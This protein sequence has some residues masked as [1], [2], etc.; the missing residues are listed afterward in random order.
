VNNEPI[1]I[2]SYWIQ[3]ALP[4]ENDLSGAGIRNQEE[5]MQSQRHNAVS[6]TT[7]LISRNYFIVH[8]T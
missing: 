5:K 4:S 8:K 6:N 7:K 1:H 2:S 3:Q